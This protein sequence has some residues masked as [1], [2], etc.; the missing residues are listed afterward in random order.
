M[1]EYASDR[2]IALESLRVLQGIDERLKQG[3]RAKRTAE[4]KLEPA[5]CRYDVAPEVYGS[6]QWN[7]QTLDHKYV[8]CYFF[9]RNNG[10]GNEVSLRMQ[11][12]YATDVEVKFAS[13]Y[14]SPATNGIDYVYTE[15]VI[16]VRD[17]PQF[18]NYRHHV[19]LN[20]SV[21]ESYITIWHAL[22]QIFINYYIG[23]DRVGVID[24]RRA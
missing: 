6:D 13:P 4:V 19:L 2:E 5:L 1:N 12:D 23:P 24:I 15:P 17:L 11:G 21:D 16:N 22:S 7:I 8:S 9:V 20:S 14:P 10:A 3:E 18:Y